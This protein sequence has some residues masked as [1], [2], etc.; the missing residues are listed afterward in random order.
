[1]TAPRSQS[2][3]AAAGAGG[4]ASGSR[5][6]SVRVPAGGADPVR[7][8]RRAAGRPRGFWQS[9]GRWSAFSGRVLELDSRDFPDGETGTAEDL[10]TGVRKAGRGTRFAGTVVSPSI[11]RDRQATARPSGR[12]FRPRDSCFR[13]SSCWGRRMGPAWLPSKVRLLTGRGP[14]ASPCRRVRSGSFS[15]W[16]PRN[17]SARKET[18]P[19]QSRFIRI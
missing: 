13:S 16:N 5:V 4:S 9:Q 8:L 14:P 15:S 11:R 3:I 6:E 12:R 10:F 18:F 2:T 7:F 17:G 1:M 19:P